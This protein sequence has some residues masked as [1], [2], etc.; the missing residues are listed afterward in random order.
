MIRPYLEM[1]K[2]SA[3]KDGVTF[4]E[5]EPNYL[6]HVKKGKLSFIMYDVDIGLNNSTSTKLA[7]SKSGTFEA[8][9]HAEIPAIEHFFLI[10]NKSRFCQDNPFN[11]AKELFEK[12]NNT[13]VLKPDN[14]RQGNNVFK[15]TN[16]SQ[17][18]EK[19]NHIF[20]LEVNAVLS[21]Y[22]ESNLE[23][24]IV[25]L[26]NIPK[27]YFAKERTYNWKH[28]LIKGALPKKVE[29]E[30]IPILDNLA[31]KAAKTL[32]LD[33]CTVDILETSEGFKVLEINEQVMLEQYSKKD[34]DFK[35][36]VSKLYNEA[37]LHRFSQIKSIRE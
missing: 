33:F 16:L 32:Q 1:I 35:S 36:Q 30:K 10:N 5:I 26:G 6:H 37:L 34:P 4:E 19:L 13:I 29:S 15:I 31:K 23:Y 18:E 7:S 25:T 3:L 27:I 14:G 8:L 2:N 11:L 21:P 17:L 9:K 12:F 28:N 22:F 24:R 20:S